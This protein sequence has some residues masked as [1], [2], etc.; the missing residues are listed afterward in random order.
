[1][2]NVGFEAGG[3]AWSPDGRWI[4][5]VSS[6]RNA[7][8]DLRGLVLVA[9]ADQEN[10]RIGDPVECLPAAAAGYPIVAAWMPGGNELAVETM[11]IDTAKRALWIVPRERGTPRQLL[12]FTREQFPAGVSVAPDGS[13]VAYVA[14]AADGFDQIFIIPAKGG[15]PRQITSDPTQK[16]QLAERVNLLASD[17]R[18]GLRTLANHDYPDVRFRIHPRHRNERFREEHSRPLRRHADPRSPQIT[19]LLDRV[20]RRDGQPEDVSLVGRVERLELDVLEASGRGRLR[21]GQSERYLLRRDILD[22][23]PDAQP[24]TVEKS[25]HGFAR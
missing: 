9:P 13:A 10:G 20:R 2:K 23:A 1:V 16:A 18:R 22:A 3:P 21:A 6:V 5:Y 17:H 15:T 19:D 8:G 14:T 25:T 12:A 7:A 4:S 24:P 11:T